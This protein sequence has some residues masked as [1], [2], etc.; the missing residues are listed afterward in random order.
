MTTLHNRH[1]GQSRRLRLLRSGLVLVQAPL[2]CVAHA[3]TTQAAGATM[4]VTLVESGFDDNDGSG[5]ITFGD[6]VHFTTTVFI[7]GV[8]QTSVKVHDNFLS[9]N[10]GT[11]QAGTTCVMTSSHTVNAAD[12]AAK[13]IVDQ[14]VATSNLFPQGVSS[15]GGG[16]HIGGGLGDLHGLTPSESQVIH[17]LE[18]ACNALQALS[19]LTPAQQDLLDQCNELAAGVSINPGAVRDA[20]NQALPHDALLQTNAGVLVT[21][22]QFDNISARIAALRSGT[23]GDHFAGLAFNTPDGTLPIDAVAGALLGASDDKQET[24]AG[25]DRWGF[26]VSGSF[27]HGF[28]AQNAATPGYGFHTNG[29]TAGVD[30]RF[31]DQWIAG[32]TAGYNNY[33]SA[34][35]VVGGGLQTR[36][37]ALSA[38]S[39]WFR[40]N[41]WYLDGVLTYADNTYDIDR[42]IVFSIP[43]GSG[44][45]VVNQDAH[46]STD[47][48]TFAGTMTFGRDFARGPFSFGPYVRG[49]WTRTDFDGYQETMLT[50]SGSGLGLV[51]QSRSSTSVESMVGAKVNMAA[52][53]P[54]GVLMP[55][56]EAEWVH[57]YENGVDRVNAHFLQDPTATP[58]QLPGDPVDT[59]FFRVGVGVSAQFTHGR[60]GFLYLE[61]TLGLAGLVETNISLGFRAEF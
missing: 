25:F 42:H 21:T 39:T 19:T 54:W 32:V 10:C 14:A 5:S 1:N 41:N 57:E 46:S 55:H 56:A 44:P 28:S 30:Y 8:T 20:I 52:S 40:A 31:N 3:A 36:G 22:A 17:A 13:Q 11:V 35:D 27:S 4:N 9:K 48:R 26:F 51:V 58:F 60:S 18:N 45:D 61:R 59:N 16:G 33:S 34:V 7:G 15:N 43:T 49:N 37:W 12:V 6:V 53:E 50:S 23:G 38:Y 47:G 29:I 2:L 24:G